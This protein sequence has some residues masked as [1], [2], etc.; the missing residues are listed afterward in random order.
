MGGCLDIWRGM[1]TCG[2]G[3]AIVGHLG[4]MGCGFLGLGWICSGRLGLADLGVDHWGYGGRLGVRG[5][6]AL[7]GGGLWWD[8]W[9]CGG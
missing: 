5:E 6:R 4:W 9:N 1:D 2:G 7:V 8:V 3:G